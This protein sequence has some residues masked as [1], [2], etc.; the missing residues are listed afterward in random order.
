LSP[1]HTSTPS[2]EADALTDAAYRAAFDA[3]T[4]AGLPTL[5]AGLAIVYA[6]LAVLDWLTAPATFAALFTASAATLALIFGIA[7]L[8]WHRWNLAPSSANRVA[9][10]IALLILGDGLMRLA[11]T[12]E[13][14]QTVRVALLMLGAGVFL[15]STRW[16][17][18]VVS[19][20]LVGWSVIVWRIGVSPS[21]LQYAT[22]QGA[23]TVMTWLAH[24]VRVRS[25]RRIEALRWREN[26][27][28]RAL[29]AS[30]T[31][32][33]QQTQRIRALL[34]IALE[35]AQPQTPLAEQLQLITQRAMEL[36]G[37]D[38]AGVWLPVTADE[39]EL[40]ATINIS[41]VQMVGRRLKLGEGL[42]GRVVATGQT[43]RVD[44]YPRAAERSG[45]FADAPFHA[46]LVVP[47]RWRGNIRG[48][49]AFTHSAPEKK[50]SAEDEQLAQLFAS[51]A[52]AA[53]ESTRLLNAA[54]NERDFA[55]QVMNTMGQGLT[56]T[57]ANGRFEYV[58]PAY[59]RMLG[60]TP[61]E[62]IG[63]MPLDYTLPED[64]AVLEQ[65]REQRQTGATT[66]YETRLR[67]RDGRLIPVLVTGAPRWRAG[68]Y[69]GA[70]A[71]VTDL[72]E[73]KRIEEDLAR[74][75]DQA[76][77]SSRLKSEFL[78]TVSHEIRTPMNSILGMT[79]LLMDTP[80]DREQRDLLATV[81]DSAQT[82]LN[83]INDI[84]DLSKIESDKLVLDRMDFD[85]RATLE[86]TV[87]LL[88][89][90][91]RE[92]HLALMLDL[93]P[94]MPHRA[95]G[96]PIRLR[97]I[98]INLIGNAIKFTEQGHVLV[99]AAIAETTATHWTLHCSVSD[100]GIGISEAARARLFQPFTQADG[101]MTR[102]YGGTGLG[103][104]ITKRLVELMNG[105]IH[106]ESVEGRGTTFTFTV[107]LERSSSAEVTSP[108]A[109]ELRGARVLIV[110]DNVAHRAILRRYVTAW[111][112]TA[113]EAA[114]AS[115]ALDALRRAV[116]AGAPFAA[117]LVDWM[118][119]EQD[120]LAFAQ[121]VRREPALDATP[122]ILL[123]AFDEPNLGARA[124][125]AGFA[126]YLTKPIRQ[127]ALLDTLAR[128]MAGTPESDD[129][130]QTTDDRRQR[131]DNR[132]QRTDD[133]R[134]T[135]DNR[136]QTTD[137]RG[138]RAESREKET[139]GQRVVLL[140]EDNPTNQKL[141][142]LQLRK[143]GLAVHAVPNG[144][145][146]LETYAATPDAFAL[147]LMDCQMP[148]MDGFTAT[149][150]IRKLELISGRHI[151][152]IAMTA[153]AMEGDREECL[154][155]GMDDYLS[156]PV[157]IEQLEQ[158]LR[159]WIP[160]AAASPKAQLSEA[161]VNQT[162]NDALDRSVLERLK[163]LQDDEHDY[164][165][166][167]ITTYLESAPQLLSTLR[168]ALAQGDTPAVQKA[169]HTLKGSSASL[170]ALQLS[171]H[172]KALELR[173]RSGSL[174]GAAEHL[175]KI[176]AEYARVA[177]ALEEV[178]AAK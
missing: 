46:A 124:R 22:M 135:S 26:Q 19:V 83:I 119:P 48:A 67:A 14:Q 5:L 108:H 18:A 107:Q 127:S 96:D 68:E 79:E 94:D 55:L 156:K 62:L 31:A 77:E 73:R 93:A 2:T 30:H 41:T 130:R 160:T 106:F 32:L 148:E 33:A 10:V 91:A 25:F 117:A 163:F 20:A 61:E 149:R 34:D 125:H 147:L 40:K 54:Q 103:L 153:N 76:M 12:A 58:N 74:A 174:D 161:P 60:Y 56:V 170:G 176:E 123:T 104:A 129:R 50:F 35:L 154:A 162:T 28:R 81:Q 102:R 109:P 132:Q 21:W 134:Q 145:A 42:A 146:A 98:L 171:E 75:R 151:P 173:A 121:A 141:A 63:T 136:Q 95:I 3:M 166:E 118:M 57:D 158:T 44:D 152:I 177:R 39:I 144:R 89:V 23:V 84:L 87:E 165:G 128:V 175:Q 71:V 66:S 53:L 29:E 155:V 105:T 99:R 80:L 11:L 9:A 69:A 24:W 43:L 159:R 97:Q 88:A 126:A 16:L 133:R 59:A 37:A 47:L 7:R 45:V 100:T 49:L 82:L 101:S 70:I 17:A 85:L 168:G 139:A 38:G 122:L 64:R 157:Q 142:M 86:G 131:T 164:L 92:K 169:A 150:A 6:V 115:D 15:L 113:D 110:D 111:G 72:T 78:A 8:R 4:L 178:R 140:A 116:N 27:Q 1:T 137:D 172:C 52:A 143:L 90:Q 51:Q 120:G 13:P 114:T 138:Q 36:L 112:M 167:L 65:A